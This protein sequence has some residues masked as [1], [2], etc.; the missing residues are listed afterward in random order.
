MDDRRGRQDE[1]EDVSSYWMTLRKRECTGNWK[2]KH[3]MAVSAEL[4][5][6][7]AMDLSLRQTAGW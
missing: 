2:G 4:A 3:K 6:E 7:E 5:L 1:E